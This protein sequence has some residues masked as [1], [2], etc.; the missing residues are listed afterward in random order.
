LAS[1]EFDKLKLWPMPVG[2]KRRG[3]AG[4]G[5]CSQDRARSEECNRPARGSLYGR[6]LP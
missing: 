3:I 2:G 6:L 5:K 4:R 1:R